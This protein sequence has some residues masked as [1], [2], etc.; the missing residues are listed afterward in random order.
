M[1]KPILSVKNLTVSLKKNKRR[2]LSNIS[3]DL[4]EGDVLAIDGKNGCGKST[5]LKII[6]GYTN[7]YEIE[8]GE[9][10]LYPYST[11][12]ILTLT[13]NELLE[14][15]RQVAF[16][17]QKDNYEG[18][19]KSTIQDLIYDAVS[20]LDEKDMDKYLDLF[21][22]YFSQKEKNQIT[23]KSSPEH[24][25]GGEQRLLSL[26][27]GL[28]CRNKSNLMI[29][30]EPLNNLDFE[31]AMN[32]SDLINNV[33]LNNPESAILMITHCKIITCINRQRKIVDGIME[34]QDSKYECHHCMGEPDCDLFYNIK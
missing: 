1:S 5:L 2:I 34:K 12:N 11:K 4:F 21:K 32:I 9:I 27:L 6:C 23:L 24:L 17:K 33:R 20:V 15:R 14:Y 18:T 29:I 16:V 8:N 3:F 30:D 26:F 31:N 13:D 10:Y 25:S 7:D 28:V 22:T 19:N